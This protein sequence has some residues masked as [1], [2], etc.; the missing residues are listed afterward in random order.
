MGVAC[1]LG[2]QIFHSSLSPSFSS[3]KHT[4]LVIYIIWDKYVTHLPSLLLSLLF[5]CL[6]NKIPT[7]PI[8]SI[9]LF[10]PPLSPLVLPFGQMMTCTFSWV[11]IS[12]FKQRKGKSILREIMTKLWGCVQCLHLFAHNK[13]SFSWEWLLQVETFQLKSMEQLSV[14]TLP[15]PSPHS[16]LHCSPLIDCRP[17]RWF[18][19]QIWWI[20]ADLETPLGHMMTLYNLLLSNPYERWRWTKK[21]STVMARNAIH[22]ISWTMGSLFSTTQV[23][24]LIKGPSVSE[25]IFQ[26]T[27]GHVITSAVWRWVWIQQIQFLRKRSNDWMTSQRLLRH[28]IDWFA[29]LFSLMIQKLWMPSVMVVLFVLLWVNQLLLSCRDDCLCLTICRVLSLH[30]S[31]RS[32]PIPRLASLIHHSISLLLVCRMNSRS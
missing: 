22:A 21:Y 4:S 19:W 29:F 16:S 15:P 11:H 30:L 7:A 6:E 14:K 18:H 32:F 9:I 12:S 5:S 24:S 1:P 17:R 27:M 2:Q 13:N 3:P 20:I 10:C 25:M 8:V 28:L 26:M 31:L 23:W